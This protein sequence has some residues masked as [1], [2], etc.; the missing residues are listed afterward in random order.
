MLMLVK[1]ENGLENEQ[2]MLTTSQMC[3]VFLHASSSATH[4]MPLRR[5]SDEKEVSVSREQVML[6]DLE[7]VLDSKVQLVS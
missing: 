3:W 2:G 5:T 4:A 1:R 6:L 7:P